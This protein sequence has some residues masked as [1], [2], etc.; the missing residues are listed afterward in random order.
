MQANSVSYD[1]VLATT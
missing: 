1:G